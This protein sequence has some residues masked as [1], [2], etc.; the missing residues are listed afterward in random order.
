V[1]APRYHQ[2]ALPDQID[3]EDAFATKATVD[4]LNAMGHGVM[5][6]GKIGDVHAVMFDR[7][8][9]VAVADPRHGGA[10]GGY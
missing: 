6:R 5:A 2:Q 7:G 4:A 9:I 8:K 3:Y 10:A 1:A